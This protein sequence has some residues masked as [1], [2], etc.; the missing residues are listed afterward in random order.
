MPLFR[1][2]LTFSGIR[3]RLS[4]RI[5]LDFLSLSPLFCLAIGIFIW[6]G[7]RALLNRGISRRTNLHL[8]PAIVC[9]GIS[10]LFLS[11]SSLSLISFTFGWELLL[12]WLFVVPKSCYQHNHSVKDV[13]FVVAITT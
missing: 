3:M 4:K 11:S 8:H 12:P 10:G 13:I 5:A 1:W 9:L 6:T 7:F 2:W